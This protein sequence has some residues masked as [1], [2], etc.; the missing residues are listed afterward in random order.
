MSNTNLDTLRNLKTGRTDWK[1]KCRI[2]REWRGV[3]QTGEVFK[4]FNLILLDAKNCMMHAFAPTAVADRLGRILQVGNIYLIKNFQVK[5][6]TDKDKFRPLHMERQIIFNSDT[7]ALQIQD[8]EIYIPNNMFDFYEFNDLKNMAKQQLNLID[9]IGIL[10]SNEMA[11]GTNNK[12]GKNH[13]NVKFKLYHGRKKINVTFWGLLAEQFHKEITKEL[14]EPVILIIAS[15]KLSTWQDEIDI[16]N[17]SPTQFY[18][19][20][21]HHSVSQL[22]K[23]LKDPVFWPDNCES[24]RKLVQLCTVSEVKNL[25]T[26]FIQEEVL[27]KA[28]LKDV[29][30]TNDWNVSVCTSCYTT[31][32]NKDANYWCPNCKRIVPSPLKRFNISAIISD[33]T[34][35][36]EIKL[37]DREMRTLLGK[38]VEELENE[39]KAFPKFITTIQGKQYTHR[40]L[41]TKENINRINNVYVTTNICEGFIFDEDILKKNTT[42][43]DNQSF[44]TQASGSSYHLDNL[45]GLQDTSTVTTTF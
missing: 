41:I 6:Y 31:T 37:K 25:G 34:G 10:H 4:N 29:K 27:C 8:S 20:Y 30:T 1:V 33:D 19:N 13:V 45:S 2:V 24:Q 5:D 43:D 23:K 39:D 32:E 22:R 9:V 14:E 44:T 38:N 12:N 3:T 17:Y 42:N 35:E 26:D 11:M 16:C 21:E 40:L 7:K 18:L 36:M 28:I 15:G